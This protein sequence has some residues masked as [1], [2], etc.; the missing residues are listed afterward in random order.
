MF[1]FHCFAPILPSVSSTPHSFS[2]PRDTLQLTDDI[3]NIGCAGMRKWF[4]YSE[5]G[6]RGEKGSFHFNVFFFFLSRTE[7]SMHEERRQ[8]VLSEKNNDYFN[9]KTVGDELI[10]I[11]SIW[12]FNSKLYFLVALIWWPKGWSALIY[13]SKM[14]L[15]IHVVYLVNSWGPKF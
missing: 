11:V 1:S 3:E 2:G 12:V 8:Q 10:A 9:S 14:F 4:Y 7:I 13:V 15:K 5:L 6:K